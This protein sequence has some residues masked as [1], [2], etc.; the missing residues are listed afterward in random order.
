MNVTLVENAKDDVNGDNRSENE[1]R[2]VRQRG[3]KCASRALKL[4]LHAQGHAYFLLDVFNGPGGFTQRRPP[5]EVERNRHRWELALMIYR[6]R[7]RS[8]F[9]MGKH[10]E[11]HRSATGR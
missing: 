9:E 7:R 10:A 3:F 1:P 4:R 8:R 6:Q 2:F 5:R 11:R